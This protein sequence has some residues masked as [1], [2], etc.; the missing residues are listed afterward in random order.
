MIKKNFLL[1]SLLDLETNLVVFPV[2]IMTHTPPE[3]GIYKLWRDHFMALLPV[4][5]T[6]IAAS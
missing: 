4:C 1:L 6:S 5:V 2:T 3:L